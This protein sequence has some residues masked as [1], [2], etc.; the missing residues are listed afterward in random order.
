[1]ERS[2]SR[3]PQT[4]CSFPL[5]CSPGLLQ[6]RPL[7]GCA[8][9][10]HLSL[11]RRSREPSAGCDLG[12]VAALVPVQGQ[13]RDAPGREPL[14]VPAALCRE[15]HYQPEGS[16]APG[17]AADLGLRAPRRVGGRRK[18]MVCV[19]FLAPEP[20]A[21][22]RGGPARPK[23][24]AGAAGA[25]ATDGAHESLLC[26]ALRPE[27]C[28]GGAAENES[29]GGQGMSPGDPRVCTRGLES[30][31]SGAG[32]GMGGAFQA[33]HKAARPRARTGPGSRVTPA[34][35]LPVV[36]S[37]SGVGPRT[38]GPRLHS[39]GRIGRWQVKGPIKKPAKENSLGFASG[40]RRE[41]GR[42]V[43]PGQVTQRRSRL[44]VRVLV[45]SSR[46]VN[47]K[48]VHSVSGQATA[49]YESRELSRAARVRQVPSPRHQD[50]GAGP[51]DAR[52][53][54]KAASLIIPAPL[55]GVCVLSCPVS[56]C[57]CSRRCSK[58]FTYFKSFVFCQI[59][60]RR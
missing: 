43:R 54:P 21:P 25:A 41:G 18:L 26:A 45:P 50:W 44:E 3:K 28:P 42:G 22:E 12:V 31:V 29:R 1:M 51:R 27:K 55:F 46:L 58:N 17:T 37:R 47:T 48:R 14:P 13:D 7:P 20:R 6:A 8:R 56:V 36:A 32:G 30:R 49:A 34:L 38:L 53:S 57:L 52:L 35:L 19:H 10:P 24:R 33:P 11:P 9:C 40:R 15:P 39:A 23:P 4:L 5:P 60:V 2:S 16:R 59:P